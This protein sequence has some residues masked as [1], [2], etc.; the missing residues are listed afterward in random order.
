MEGDMPNL[1]RFPSYAVLA[2]CGFLVS[3]PANADS[4]ERVSV[5]SAGNQ[6]S[7]GFSAL[8]SISADGRFVAFESSAT[9]LV[10]NDTN[11][12]NDVFVHDRQTGATERVSVDSNG[13]QADSSSSEA[14]ISA[15]GRFVAFQSAATNLVDGDTNG[16]L[17]V[18]VH[19]RVPAATPRSAPTAVS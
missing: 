19:D 5:T 11:G 15:D 1:R 12:T 6:V 8:P 4:T 2:I 13:G 14:S 7:G 16:Q 17:D 3:Q 10:A 9:D 18:F